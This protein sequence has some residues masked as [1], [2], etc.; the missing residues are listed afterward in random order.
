MALSHQVPSGDEVLHAERFARGLGRFHAVTFAPAAELPDEDYPFY[1]STG[2]IRYHYHTGTMT[3][4]SPGLDAIAPEER[5]QMH[6]VD[7][8][9]LGIHEGE[10]AR[11]VTRRG[12]VQARVQ[13][14][15]RSPPGLVF[16]TFHFRE[17]PMNE[18]THDALDPVAKIPE[19]KVCAVRVERL[20]PGDDIEVVTPIC[21]EAVG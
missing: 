19:Y 5:V 1:L 9:R 20:L 6:P 8:E 12:A 13:I 3:R 16:G 11:L 10:W 18:L 14:T 21:R 17:V 4:R 2:R 15:D 7:A